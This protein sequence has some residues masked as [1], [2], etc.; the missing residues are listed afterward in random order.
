MAK[1]EFKKLTQFSFVEKQPSYFFFI[2]NQKIRF[3]R[4]ST[5]FVGK[6]FYQFLS[7]FINFQKRNSLI[8]N[9]VLSIYLSIF[10][11]DKNPQATVYGRFGK[12][13]G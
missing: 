2:N 10:L 13:S 12:F 7:I 6:K 9:E 8:I 1:N 4:I 11:N 3:L 5:F